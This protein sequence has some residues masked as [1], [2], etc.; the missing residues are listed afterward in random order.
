MIVNFPDRWRA[1]T[2]G[3]EPVSLMDQAPTIL[4]IAEVSDRMPLD[5]QSLL[6]CVKGTAPDTREVYSES[7]TNGVY[8]PCFMIRRGKYKYVYIHGEDAQLFDLVEDPG[9]WNDLA[10]DPAFQDIEE[11]LRGRI[12]QRFAPD[13]IE[14]ELQRSLENRTII[15]TALHLNDTHWDYAPQWDVTEQ[16]VR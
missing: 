11:E 9:E 10:G 15:K 14:R 3:E 6:S 12:L 16:Y 2:V 7:H 5:A 4:D 8:A 1:G 13:A